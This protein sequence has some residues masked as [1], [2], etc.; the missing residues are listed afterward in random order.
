MPEMWLQEIKWKEKNH[1]TQNLLD[2]TEIIVWFSKWNLDFYDR[3][4]Q[5][6]GGASE[7]QD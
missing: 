2:I 7:A 5:I 6:V 3:N 4:V 1:L